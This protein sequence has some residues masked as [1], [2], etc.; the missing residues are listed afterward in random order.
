MGKR[1]VFL[2]TVTSVVP[3]FAD[4]AQELLPPQ[5]E[6]WHVVDE[7]LAKVVVAKGQLSPFIYRRVADHARAAEEAGASVLQITCSSIGPCAGTAATQV[8]IAVLRVDEPMV[9]QAVALG[10]RVGVAATAPTALAPTVDLVN[11]CARKVSK[12]IEVEAMVCSEA[13][14]GL[15]SGDLELHDRLVRETLEQMSRRNDVILLAQASMARVVEGRP[16]ARKI[17]ILTSPRPAVQRLALF[18]NAI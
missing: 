1:V 9:E 13:Y 2:H 12:P 10:T 18:V 8:G 6:T 11:E 4:L 15:M 5:V 3:Q 16:L 14:A 7:M 17:P